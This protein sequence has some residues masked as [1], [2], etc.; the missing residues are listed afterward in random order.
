MSSIDLSKYQQ[1]PEPKVSVSNESKDSLTEK[2]SDSLSKD[3]ALFDKK[4][5]Q[6]QKEAFYS[7]LGLLLS[8]GIDI[9]T[10]IE[11]IEDQLKV[12]K[13]KAIL[14]Q[15]KDTIFVNSSL[16]LQQI[17][18]KKNSKQSLKCLFVYSAF[19]I[20]PFYHVIFIRANVFPL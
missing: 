9:K 11:I 6:T 15:I 1:K 7:E 13:H 10:A 2:L 5:G 14:S 19:L 3:I 20:P 8:S 4:F 17:V 12:K 16:I 18:Y